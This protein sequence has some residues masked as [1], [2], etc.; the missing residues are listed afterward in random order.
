MNPTPIK[1]LEALTKRIC[2]RA[3]DDIRVF[4]DKP[5]LAIYQQAQDDLAL[6]ETVRAMQEA[7]RW[8]DVNEEKEFPSGLVLLRVYRPKFKQKIVYVVGYFDHEIGCWMSSISFV[9]HVTHYMPLPEPPQ[10][11]E[12]GDV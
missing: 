7:L 5:Q 4:A 1:E 11:Q 2:E 6:L 9:H 8:R 10:A 3:E 12:V